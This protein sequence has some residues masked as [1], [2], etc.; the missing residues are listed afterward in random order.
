MFLLQYNVR[1]AEREGERESEKYKVFTTSKALS[2]TEC[3]NLVPPHDK[4][5]QITDVA[6]IS[7][8]LQST[9]AHGLP[10]P[11]WFYA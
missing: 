7:F 1:K 5:W 3:T 11:S 4:P 6:L 10:M 8:L 2:A 9:T